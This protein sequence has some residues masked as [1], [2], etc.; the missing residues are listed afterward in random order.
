MGLNS[1]IIVIWKALSTMPPKVLISTASVIP[2]GF[3][4]SGS[5]VAPV[6]ATVVA[7]HP[8][9]VVASHPA[10]P[11]APKAAPKAATKAAPL[12]CA[13]FNKTG[14]PCSRGQRCRDEKCRNASKAAGAPSPKPAGK[15]GD[16][17]VSAQISA[18][19]SQLSSMHTKVDNLTNQVATGFTE[20]KSILT[21][22]QQAT[23]GMQKAMEAMML[24]SASLQ[25]GITG[26]ITGSASRPE[27]SAPSAR[28]AICS[29]AT[30]VVERPVTRG[31]GSSASESHDSGMTGT[32]I[33]ALMALCSKCHFPR[34]GHVYNVLCA[35]F[36]TKPVS[37]HHESLLS[38]ISEHT[39]NDALAAL[40]FLLLTGSQQFTKASFSTFCT[41]CDFLLVSNRTSTFVTFSQVCE[42]FIKKSPKWEIKKKDSVKA[43]NAQLKDKS[44]YSTVFNALVHNF[45]S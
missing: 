16:G 3:G 26:L 37:E 22:Q 4:S 11:A 8:A 45:L 38:T 1:K 41:E 18:I 24:A 33:D 23:L 20:T 14:K 2:V 43:S 31:G 39:K 6:A 15:G 9:T 30:E 27:L 21:E 12:E 13:D 40:L 42:S 19:A 35:L 44:S 34:Q 5:K 36:G 28:R 17:G 25:S 10:I 7:S 32:H 29:P